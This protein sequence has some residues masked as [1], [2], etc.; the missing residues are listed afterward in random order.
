MPLQKTEAAL[1]LLEQ[2]GSDKTGVN[3]FL[4]ACAVGKGLYA[5]VRSAMKLDDSCAKIAIVIPIGDKDDPDLL[6]CTECSRR[7]FGVVVCKHCKTEFSARQKLRHGGL[8]A[9][10]FLVTLLQMVPPLLTSMHIMIRKGILSAQARQEMTEEA[11]RAGCTYIM[12]IDDDTLFP[13]KTIYDFHNVM[14]RNPDIGILTGVYVTREDQCEPLLYKRYGE[15]A[16]WTFDPTEGHLEDVA[17]AGAGCMMARVDALV[18]VMRVHQEPWWL[19]VQDVEFFNQTGQRSMW[20]HDIRF[21]RNLWRTWQVDDVGNVHPGP[22]GQRKNFERPKDDEGRSLDF[23]TGWPVDEESWLA[24]PPGHPELRYDSVERTWF[25]DD[26]TPYFEKIDIE[27]PVRELSAT[28]PPR[29]PWRVAVAGWTQCIHWDV[30]RQMGFVVP[31]D[32]PCFK[33]RNTASYWDHL[34]R[35]EGHATGRV[36]PELYDRICALVPEDSKVVDVG[37]GAGILMEKLLKKRHC[38]VFGIDHSR[39]AIELLRQRDLEG[40]SQDVA[41]LQLNHFPTEETV[42]VS[43][44]TIEHLDDERLA[45]LFSEASKAKSA[46]FSTPEGD[47]PGTPPGEHVQV[48]TGES[49]ENRLAE[50]FHVVTIERLETKDRPTNPYLIACCS[51]RKDDVG[52]T[53][54]DLVSVQRDDALGGNDLGQQPH[55]REHHS[56]RHKSP[57]GR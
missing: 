8:V 39:Q 17:Y 24:I 16:Y 27:V 52:R 18:D 41:E 21:C 54:S 31:S 32:A 5:P 45:K 13:P 6:T 28:D 51:G 1:Q 22:D 25:K 43:T 47:L 29:R 15:G 12:Y 10:E 4:D 40:S 3:A 53:G 11:V 2:L 30:R 20:G 57:A 23:F 34:W 26:L 33:N 35:A 37:C 7:Q 48:W 14:E 49:L 19:D 46:I 36:Y 55:D 44:E 56:Q 42:V 9:A 50:F 38:R